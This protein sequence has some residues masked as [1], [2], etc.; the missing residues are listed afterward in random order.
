MYVYAREKNKFHDAERRMELFAWGG[1]VFAEWRFAICSN[2]GHF[3]KRCTFDVVKIQ[4]WSESTVLDIG[5]IVV[6]RNSASRKFA[7]KIVDTCPAESLCGFN[8]ACANAT[9]IKS[10]WG[11]T[12]SLSGLVAVDVH[13]GLFKNPMLDSPSAWK[14]SNCIRWLD[15]VD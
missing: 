15:I 8:R 9:Y 4:E 13:I 10:L 12:C 2:N 1:L 11:N 6:R 3:E 5:N 14:Y 7:H